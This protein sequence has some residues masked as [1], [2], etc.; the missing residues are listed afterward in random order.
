MKFL[1]L[2][3][4]LAGSCLSEDFDDLTMDQRNKQ[5]NK[6]SISYAASAEKWAFRCYRPES[7][8]ECK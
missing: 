1:L 5:C 4:L 7:N 3:L 2:S 8:T 6:K